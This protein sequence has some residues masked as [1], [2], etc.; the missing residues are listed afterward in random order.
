MIQHPHTLETQITKTVRL[1]YLLHLPRDYDRAQKFPLILF[2]HGSGERG[3]DL[4]QIK[5]FGIPRMLEARDDFPFIVVSPQCPTESD[6]VVLMD[7][8]I[9]LLD[10][11]LENFAVDRARVYLT[12]LS[13][14]GRGAYQLA[15]ITPQSFA[16]MVVISARRPDVLR[17]PD[18]A[19]ALK[20]IPIW[21]FHGAQDTRVPANES[22]EIERA[23]RDASG[24]V[25][26]TIYP[27][28]GHDAWT[29]TYENPKLYDWLLEHKKLDAEERR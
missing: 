18:R 14:G 26:L 29:R 22:I 2:L 11:T 12:G 8:L 15:F 23:L 7:D 3:N 27:D 13:M 4:E 28:A 21:I 10:H 5:R 9:A 19:T 24:N 16:A 25:R 17:A 1:N 20:H 6:W